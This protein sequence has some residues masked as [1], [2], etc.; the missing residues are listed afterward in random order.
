MLSSNAII[1]SKVH[2]V[3]DSETTKDLETIR[4]DYD[5]VFVFEKDGRYHVWNGLDKYFPS[6]DNVFCVFSDHG[7][8]NHTSKKYLS[9]AYDCQNPFLNVQCTYSNGKNY[10]HRYSFAKSKVVEKNQCDQGKPNFKC[11]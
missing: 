9:I 6:I 2:F 8:L 3:P 7:Y 1:P 5:V 10:D 4:K 11:C